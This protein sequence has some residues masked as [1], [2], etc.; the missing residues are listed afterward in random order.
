M[1]LRK[2]RV[3]DFKEWAARVRAYDKAREEEESRRRQKLRSREL[4]ARLT[5]DRWFC[6]SCN[7]WHS[8]ARGRRDCLNY[9]SNIARQESYVQS[10]LAEIE[11][12]DEYID[13]VLPHIALN[14]NRWGGEIRR[15]YLKHPVIGPYLLDASLAGKD[16]ASLSAEQA[17]L[18][19]KYVPLVK[20]IAKQYARSNAEL[21]ADL[22]THGMETLTGL[23]RRYDAARGF[24]F[25][26]LAKPWLLGAMRERFLERVHEIAVG[27]PEK[28]YAAALQRTRKLPSKPN[29][30]GPRSDRHLDKLFDRIARPDPQPMPRSGTDQRLDELFARDSAAAKSDLRLRRAASQRQEELRKLTARYLESGGSI[31]RRTPRTP[32][33]TEDLQRTIA[34]LNARQQAVYRGRVLTDPPVT[35]DRLARQLGIRDSTQISRIQ[36]QAE[37]KVAK[38]LKPKVSP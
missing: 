6:E 15:R 27:D 17:E 3:I 13:S 11:R 31:K 12:G 25:G 7:V 9:L 38:I 24:T 14:I 5:K 34:K 36:R 21:R 16:D 37:C 1:T 28:V 4:S 18:V 33:L 32:T 23:V 22:E 35:R 10:R 30:D 2:W 8:K 29:E 20:S 19:R 26:A